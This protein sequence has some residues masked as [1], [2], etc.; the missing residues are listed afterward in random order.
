LDTLASL[1]KGWGHDQS[2]KESTR[3]GQARE[4]KD[5]ERRGERDE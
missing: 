4:E 5:R 3:E 1:K 2:L